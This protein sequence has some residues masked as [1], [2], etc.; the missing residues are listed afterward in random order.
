MRSGPSEKDPNVNQKINTLPPSPLK[1]KQMGV[2]FC[3]ESTIYNSTG[4]QIV[5]SRAVE[6]CEK[7]P[8]NSK[9]PAANREFIAHGR[10]KCLLLCNGPA[11]RSF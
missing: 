7:W 3:L 6:E 10:R 2:R 8:E 11:E 5:Q 4:A 9:I 1:L